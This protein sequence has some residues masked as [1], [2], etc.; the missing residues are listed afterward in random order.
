VYDGTQQAGTYEVGIASVNLPPGIYF[1]RLI[2]PGFAETKK[3]V[4]SR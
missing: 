4:V 1:Y 3:M 2:A